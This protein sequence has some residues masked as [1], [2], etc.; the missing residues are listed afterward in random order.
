MKEIIDWLT[1]IEEGAFRLYGQAALIFQDDKELASLL[2]QL[3]DDEKLHYELMKKAGEYLKGDRD[4]PSI[5]TLDEETK[6]R[7]ERPFAELRG[8]LSSGALSRDELLNYVIVLEFSE[9]NHIFLYVM[10]SLTDESRR[11]FSAAALNIEHHKERIKGF[12]HARPG[13]ER[14]LERLGGLPRVL[15]ERILIVDDKGTNLTLLKAVLEKEGLIESARN[16]DDAL[17]KVESSYF[18]AIVTDIDM[19]LMSGLEFY[20]RATEMFPA[21]KDRFVF[22]TASAGPERIRFFKDNHLRYIMK[23]APISDIRNTVREVLA[24]RVI[25]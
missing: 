24:N 16:G 7:V 12:L 8:K 21:I 25:D 18:S 1:G 23:P 11:H 6:Q 3:S 19:P 5:I 17:R 9:L 22:F 2:R 20:R 15:K 10:D 13:S 14:S 4:A